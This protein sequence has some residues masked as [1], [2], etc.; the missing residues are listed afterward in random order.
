VTIGFTVSQ[1]A[2]WTLEIRNDAGRLVRHVAGE[3]KVIQTVWGGRDDDGKPLPD[4]AYALQV[5][6]TSSAGEAR[7][8]TGTVRLDTNPPNM[9][10]ADVT[11]DPFSPNGDGQDD[12]ARIGFTPAEAVQARLSVVDGSGNVLR[13]LKSWAWVAASAQKASWDGRILSGGKLTPAPEGT[14][15]VQI[16]IR[17]TA[18]NTTTVRRRVAIDRTLALGAVS[19]PTFSPNGDGVYDDATLSFTL[20]RAADVSATVLHAGSGVRTMRLGR[21]GKGKQSVTWDGKLGGGGVATSGHYTLKLTADGALGVTSAAKAVTVDLVAPR[22]T[23]PATV[24]VAYRKTAKI[25]YTARDAFSTKVKVGATVTDAAGT[26]V[27][28][29]NLG[30]VNQGAVHVCAWRPRARGSFTVTYKAVDLGG[31]HLAA[32]VVTTVK[33][34]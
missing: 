33:V 21:L 19:R 5:D 7:P 32:T 17:D 11:P 6:A 31:N 10:S 4:G 23:V 18:G 16:E 20:T 22:L 30:W 27:A 12:V 24:R 28:S 13:R 25:A 3:G 1:Q 34:R 8:A 29:L 15:T 2:T 14:A 9:E 26:V